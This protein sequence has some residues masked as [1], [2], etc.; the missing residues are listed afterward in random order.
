MQR[1]RAEH[2]EEAKE[3]NRKY[4]AERLLNDEYRMWHNAGV[5][6]RQ[7]LN[8]CKTSGRR[9]E[10]IGC[11]S[12]Y[13]FKHIE[14]QFTDE[15]NWKDKGRLNSKNSNKW[16]VD[17]IVPKSAFG[18]LSL[19]SEQERQFAIRVVSNWRNLQP[20]WG[21]ENIGTKGSKACRKSLEKLM[22]LLTA[23]PS[24]CSEADQKIVSTLTAMAQFLLDGI[25]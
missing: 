8:G 17:H 23:T 2:P 10:I 14:S 21:M 6:I 13:L 3:K 22:I 16:H 15:M 7:M 4:K 9:S 19:L 11:N 12:L 20:M 24:D 25:T 18:D 5:M 1:Y